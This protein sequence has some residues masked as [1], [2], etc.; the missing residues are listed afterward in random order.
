MKRFTKWLS[1]AV[2]S[3]LMVTSLLPVTV[4]STV[5]AAGYADEI[6]PN[7]YA[8]DS[9]LVKLQEG[10]DPE[11]FASQYDLKVEQTIGDWHVMQTPMNAAYD[12]YEKLQEDKEAAF[13]E[14]N[15]TTKKVASSI[16]KRSITDLC[17]KRDCDEIYKPKI[18]WYE[19]MQAK[20]VHEVTIG[21]KEKVIAMIGT[22]VDI[23]HPYLEE[24]I[25]SPY[26][27]VDQ[28][29]EPLDEDGLGTMEAGIAAGAYPDETSMVAMDKAAR[30]MPLKVLNK[31]GVGKLSDVGEALVYAR[32]KGASVAHLSLDL[33][34]QS[35]FLFD[36][37]NNERWYRSIIII[38][39][40][41]G[42]PKPIPPRPPCEVCGG[43]INDLRNLI[44]VQPL[45]NDLTRFEGVEYGKWAHFGV[46]AE[47]YFAPFAE[48]QFALAS[49][50]S[51]ASA[52]VAGAATLTWSMHPEASAEDVLTHL[53]KTANPI[54]GT[55]EWFNYG[56]PD[57]YKAVS[58]F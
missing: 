56:M 43:V 33:K 10:V 13:V 36:M 30:I 5:Q 24:K 16:S 11:K 45:R 21:A 26:N 42:P 57:V 9:I 6:Q 37:I 3:I 17:L 12:Y 51:L 53:Q 52:A 2:A 22:G 47:N 44:N 48:G 7:E 31:E 20:K 34:Y 28:N 19:W 41:V 32:E 14:L 25:V 49:G 46:P 50:A 40:I 23:K 4:T 39:V 38:I 18:P 29:E 35:Q 55:G 1:T 8:P 27:F 15:L 54:E 58:E